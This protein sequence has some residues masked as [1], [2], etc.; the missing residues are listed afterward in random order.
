MARR[1]FP[2][3]IPRLAQVSLLGALMFFSIAVFTFAKPEQEE[4]GWRLFPVTL[5]GLK[6]GMKK[7]KNNQKYELK[8][9]EELIHSVMPFR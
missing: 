4:R 9:G 7:F 8:V 2:L 1:S 3:A 6:P 5:C